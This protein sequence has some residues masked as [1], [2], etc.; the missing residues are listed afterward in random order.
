MVRTLIEKV[1]PVLVNVVFWDPMYLII[2][3]IHQ[4]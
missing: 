1:S 4:N 3:V 2:V